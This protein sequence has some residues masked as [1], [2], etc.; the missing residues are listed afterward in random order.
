M[1]L[2]QQELFTLPEHS[3]FLGGVRVTRSLGLCACFGLILGSDKMTEMELMYM[4]YNTKV[5]MEKIPIKQITNNES[6]DHF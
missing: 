6:S 1:P 3:R 2:I 4:N 5:S